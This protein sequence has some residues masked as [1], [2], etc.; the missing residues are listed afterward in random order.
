MKITD[1]STY[2]IPGDPRRNAWCSRKP[3][4]FVRVAASSGIVGWG[5]GYS[6]SFREKVLVELIKA[7]GERLVGSDAF[8]TKAVTH[9]AVN[10]FGEQQVGIDVFAAASALEIALWDIVGKSLGVPV[11]KLLGG[12]CHASL[13]VYANIWTK[14]PHSHD[15][16]AAKAVEQ[17]E[18][19][20]GTV[21]IYPF[22][23]GE[24]LP[25]GVEK[26][27][28]VREAVGTDVGIAIDV[29]R[30]MTPDLTREL[31]S[32]LEPLDAAWIEDPFA[33]T[34]P[35]ALRTLRRQIRQPLMA[36]ETL[37]GKRA[38]R[39]LLE[40]Q[41]VSLLNPD[42]CACGGILE[43]REV[44]AM[45]EV[46]EISVSPHNYNSMTVGLAATVQTACGI[47]NLQVCEYF[48]EMASDLD[49]LCEGRLIPSEGQISLPQAPGHG[50]VFD[51][52]KMAPYRV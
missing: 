19:G 5:E 52:A 30:A 14:H 40:Q 17:V 2:L 39:D 13:G 3:Y 11:Y 32:R 12:T 48:P 20:F 24:S 49:E 8:D 25:E 45:A 47:P 31:C 23:L 15:D 37:A 26:V 43:M 16:L 28:R 34:N 10:G 18:N 41:A 9:L 35:G 29:F 36:G 33:D 22:R 4:V 46:Q 1:I 38:F 51:D 6:F 50:I 27:R 7:L 21:K 42:V 44:S